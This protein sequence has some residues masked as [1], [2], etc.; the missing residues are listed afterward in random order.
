MKHRPP[1]ADYL[2]AAVSRFHAGHVFRRFIAATAKAADVQERILLAKV[3]R[4]ADSDFGRRFHFDAIRSA[5]DFIRR[6]PI[7]SYEDHQPYIERVKAGNLKALFGG[8]QRVQM[9]AMSSGTTAEPKYIP[10]TGHFLREYR[11]GWNAWGIKALLD[12]REAMLRRI[13]QVSSRMDEARTSAGIA[14]GAITGLMA[15]TQKRL[16]R[17]Y[18]VTPPCLA[19]IDDPAA[20]YYTIMRLSVPADV[21]FV[22]AASPATQIKLARTA[23]DHREQLIRDIYDGRL[24][25]ELPVPSSV[26]EQ[27]RP[28]LK[29]DPAQAHRLESL[30]HRHGRLLPRHYWNLSFLGNWTGG[31]MSLYLPDL[32]E[33]FG[34]APV[35]DIGLLASEGR[36]SIPVDDDTPAGILDVTSN[37]FEF[38][39]KDRIDEASPPAFRCHEL[40]AAQEYFVL[41]TTSAGLYRYQLGDVVRVVGRTGQ[42]PIVEFL[43]KGAHVSSTAGE[44]LTE[45]QVILA[46]QRVAAALDIPLAAC[47]LAPHWAQ[48]PFYMLHVAAA[49]RPV[50]AD[51]LAA[52]I[53][54]A[55]QEINVEYAGKRR[56]DRLGPIR[57]NLVPAQFLADLDRRR[58]ERY[59][60]GNEQ[61]KHQYLYTRPGDDAEFPGTSTATASIPLLVPPDRPPAGQV[62]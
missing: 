34:R 48:P 22:V 32:P 59:R 41:L 52:A 4:N 39:P 21:A 43:N 1:L 20:K 42:A 2:L 25:P 30:V 55:L 33:Y 61:Y 54:Q 47:V 50:P 14:C 3:R 36:V 17:K 46:V 10:V 13:V 28:R 15:A 44:K 18:Y 62:R 51:H 38:V 35:R 53:D 9:F 49:D 16:V 12:H 23:D 45:R 8:R 40:D 19:D 26:R 5:A 60:R 6:V 58:A 57:V 31:T 29:P 27:L 7:L 24:W 37:F 11:A 56:S